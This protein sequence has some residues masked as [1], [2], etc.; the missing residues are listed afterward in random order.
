MDIILSEMERLQKRL[1][2]LQPFLNKSFD[3]IEEFKQDKALQEM[4]VEYGVIK[5]RMFE[6]SWSLKDAAEKKEV[7]LVKIKL[8]EKYFDENQ[9][10]ARA[11]YMRD[12]LALIDLLT[13]M[14]MY[15]VLDEGGSSFFANLLSQ[16]QQHIFIGLNV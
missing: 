7:R 2:E 4:A 3:T 12:Y 8:A 13:K 11:A 6:L 9:N 15:D 10:E 14:N 5:K 16:L 1:D